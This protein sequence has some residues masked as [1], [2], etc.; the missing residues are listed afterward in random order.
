MLDGNFDDPRLTDYDLLME[1]PED[2]KA[3][4]TVETPVYS[5]KESKRVGTKTVA[6]PESQGSSSS[7]VSTR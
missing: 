5:F 3:G 1:E 4:K 6:C 2:L 7:R